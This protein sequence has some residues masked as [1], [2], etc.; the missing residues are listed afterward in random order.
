M[1]ILTWTRP[2]PIPEGVKEAAYELAQRAFPR[3]FL[4][5]VA[6]DLQGLAD[7]LQKFGVKVHRPAPH[8][9]TQLYSV[10]HFGPPQAIT[11]TIRAT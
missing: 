6:E 5:E 11:F 10:P 7:T 4:D 3:W 1:G 8:D 2:T 9:L